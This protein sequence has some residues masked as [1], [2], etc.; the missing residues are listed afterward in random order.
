MATVPRT[1][2]MAD[3]WEMAADAVPEREALV[4]GEQR[5]TYAQLE[6]PVKKQ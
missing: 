1:F 6:E 2:N 3:V 5:R 4:V